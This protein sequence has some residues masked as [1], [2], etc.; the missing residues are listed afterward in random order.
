MRKTDTGIQCQILNHFRNIFL[1]FTLTYYLSLYSELVRFV[2]MHLTNFYGKSPILKT[3]R[4]GH[5]IRNHVCMGNNF[6]Y[7]CNLKTKI[8][9]K[10]RNVNCKLKIQ[11]QRVF[12]SNAREVAVLEVRNRVFILPYICL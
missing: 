9:K 5:E 8:K 2:E 10:K 6:S 7:S 11:G 1:S 3:G 12:S 4:I